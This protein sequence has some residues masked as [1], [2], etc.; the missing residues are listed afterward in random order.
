MEAAIVAFK[1]HYRSLVGIDACFLKGPYKV[2]LM[3][4][5]GLNENNCQFSLAYGVAPCENE[6]GWNLF[7]HAL[8]VALDATENSSH[9]TFMSDRHKVR[10][11]LLCNAPIKYC[12]KIFL[13]IDFL[14]S[15]KGIIK[16]LKKIMPQAAR[17]ICV[18][19]IYKNFACNFPDKFANSTF[20]SHFP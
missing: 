6:K 8:V 20:K 2:M 10:K 17:R 7:I 5:M 4:A 1:Q 3:T 18:L 12:C 9:Y 13:I 14:F 15:L 16:T 19:H 11:G